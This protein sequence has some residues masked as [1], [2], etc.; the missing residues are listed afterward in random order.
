MDKTCIQGQHSYMLKIMGM[1]V[2]G[3]LERGVGEVTGQDSRVD[4]D[5]G[6][7]VIRGTARG[8]ETICCSLI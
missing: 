5:V 4:K 1:D 6:Q 7:D 2:I 8:K 3:N